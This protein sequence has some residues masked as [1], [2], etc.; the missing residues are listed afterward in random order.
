MQKPLG[1]VGSIN[2]D[3]RSSS[4]EPAAFPH[5]CVH[6]LTSAMD[7]WFLNR[8]RH[9]FGQH[10]FELGRLCLAAVDCAAREIFDMARN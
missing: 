6:T 3:T 7:A 8:S 9:L 1:T 10:G 4:G 2:G 5:R